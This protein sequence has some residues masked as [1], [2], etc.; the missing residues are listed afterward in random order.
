MFDFLVSDGVKYL[1]NNMY[2]HPEEWDALND[3]YHLTNHKKD[4]S[5]WVANGYWFYKID[6]YN[7]FNLV[8]RWHIHKAVLFLRNHHMVNKVREKNLVDKFKEDSSDGI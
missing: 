6:G 3:K 4:I 2:N 7:S 5:I 1:V 8:E